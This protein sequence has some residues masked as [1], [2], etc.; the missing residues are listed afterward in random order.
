MTETGHNSV[1]GK[2]LKFYIDRIEA[3]DAEAR[4]I[5]DQKAQEFAAMKANGFDKRAVKE[6][7]RRRKMETGDREEFLSLVEMYESALGQ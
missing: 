6:I 2:Q 5:S 4:D 3:L 1:A 7:L